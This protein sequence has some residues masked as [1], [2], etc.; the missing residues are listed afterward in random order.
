MMEGRLVEGV[1]KEGEGDLRLISIKIVFLNPH[2][3]C[4]SSDYI[5]RGLS[6]ESTLIFRNDLLLVSIIMSCELYA[7]RR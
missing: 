7:P 6:V 4:F 5:Y 2:F 1:F 3:L